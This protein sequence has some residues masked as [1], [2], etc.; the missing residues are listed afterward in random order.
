MPAGFSLPANKV[1]FNGQV[2]W[3]VPVFDGE[4]WGTVPPPAPGTV[5]QFN[6]RGRMSWSKLELG[7]SVAGVLPAAMG[8]TGR[9]SYAPGDLLC[10]APGGL[11][12]VSMGPEGS[13]LTV[14]GNRLTWVRRGDVAGTGRPGSLAL[15]RG[16]TTIGS[17]P[18]ELRGDTLHFGHV[19]ATS[20]TAN[21]LL[22]GSFKIKQVDGNLGMGPVVI[23]L[24]GTVTGAG[25]DV[26]CVR[27]VLPATGG[28]T[29]F[30][31]YMPGEM[32][33]A[34]SEQTLT[35]LSPGPEGSL[36]AIS[37]GSPAWVPG[38][39]AFTIASGIPVTDLQS[40]LFPMPHGG[41]WRVL[42]VQTA[43]SAGVADLRIACD[44][45]HLLDVTA[46]GASDLPVTVCGGSVLSF[47]DVSWITSPARITIVLIAERV[48]ER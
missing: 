22:I 28:G 12:V 35:R 7:S 45:E 20:I 19:S 36:M 23:A 3:S 15:W 46:E 41:F 2:K 34:G 10:G 9:A 43:I 32:L 8:G 47:Y 24:D 18:V 30:G 13:S 11:G 39:H 40:C 26:A 21:D 48:N 6:H 42:S 27:G 25:I 37:G 31:Q 17:A 38:W 29:G 1:I 44:G 4:S 33:I 16:D 14:S 5:L